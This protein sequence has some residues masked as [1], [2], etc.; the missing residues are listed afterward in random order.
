[1][2]ARPVARELLQA[3]TGRNP[4]VVDVL[5]R[6]EH[7]QFAIR[8]ALQVGAEFLDMFPVPH[9]LGVP[10]GEPLDHLSIVTRRVMFC[11][12]ERPTPTLSDQA[13]ES[14]LA[15]IAAGELPRGGKL[16]ERG[17]TELLGVS[18]TPIREALQR[19]VQDRQIE[20]LG[21]RSLRVAARLEGSIEEVDEVER[22]LEWRK[23]GSDRGNKSAPSRV[24][25]IRT[26]RTA[27]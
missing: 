18:P 13:Y 2:L 12:D 15:A 20:R 24:T 3:V 14:I 1:V 26:I 16:T 25:R 19:L 6:V 11:N 23:K 8:D 17:L 9:T 10:I 21:P 7:Q 22:V 27:Q 4:E 5:G